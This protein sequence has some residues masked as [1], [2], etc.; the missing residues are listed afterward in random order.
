V[1]IDPVCEDQAATMK[2]LMSM[3]F[4]RPLN[5]EGGERTLDNLARAYG[6][7]GHAVT[8]IAPLLA[9]KTPYRVVNYY[10]PK[11][12]TLGNMREY[13]ACLRKH[14]PSFDIIHLFVISPGTN[15][16]SRSL[17]GFEDKLFVTFGTPLASVPWKHP[18]SQNL[19]HY[20]AK[21]KFVARFWP[22]RYRKAVVS[23]RF[24]KDQLLS[25]GI[26]EKK[27]RVFSSWGIAPREFLPYSRDAAKKGFG[28]Q[29]KNVVSYIGHFHHIK[30]V[31]YLIK[32]FELLE[33]KKA[34]LAIAWSKKGTQKKKVLSMI[35]N[36]PKRDKIKMFYTVDVR[37]F[38]AASE[39][40]VLPYTYLSLPHYPLV[41]LEAFAMGVP[42]VT[43]RV[44]GIPELVKDG[45][46]GFLAQPCDVDSLRYAID[47]VLAD[48]A[49][50]KNIA[51]NEL[52]DF[53][54]FYNCDVVARRYLRL[55]QNG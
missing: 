10:D 30:G 35:K 39:V 49:K 42:V 38:L 5:L 18:N 36:S 45:S 55:F 21:N 54:R 24:Q 26:P 43:T 19:F 6:N 50:A 46:T 48:P 16:T 47:A 2:I 29:G 37:K 14:A 27:I 44:G 41:I 33:D 13:L 23:T 52:S 25:L 15:F 32:A 22:V 40:T 51:K 53:H 34:V 12:G 20:L 28:L 1:D 8:V 7:A 17:Q 3:F 4:I 9:T 31:P 11:K